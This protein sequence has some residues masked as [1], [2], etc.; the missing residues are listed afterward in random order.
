MPNRA[1]Y[2]M[3]E[4]LTHTMLNMVREEQFPRSLLGVIVQRVTARINSKAEGEYELLAELRSIMEQ[5]D[6]EVTAEL[7]VLYEQDEENRAVAAAREKILSG[8]AEPKDS[9]EGIDPIQA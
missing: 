3:T 6:R 9:H 2:V 1:A 5:T 8:T 4:A 7:R